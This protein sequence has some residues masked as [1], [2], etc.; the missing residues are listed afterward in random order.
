MKA[1]VRISVMGRRQDGETARR[2]DDKH[3]KKPIA[4]SR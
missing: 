2:Q 3:R 4:D 1:G